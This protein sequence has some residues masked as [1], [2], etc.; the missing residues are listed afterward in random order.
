MSEKAGTDV[1]VRCGEY[2]ATVTEYSLFLTARRMLMQTLPPPL[3][4]SSTVHARSEDEGD[5][6][7]AATCMTSLL[8]PACL[9]QLW[10]QGQ[11]DNE[12]DGGVDERKATQSGRGCAAPTSS[13]LMFSTPPSGSAT[14]DRGWLRVQ[15]ALEYTSVTYGQLHAVTWAQ[16]EEIRALHYAEYTP[17]RAPHCPTPADITASCVLPVEVVL[18]WVHEG[19][20]HRV[21]PAELAVLVATAADH[22]DTTS[23]S[24]T[25][26][27][28]A[29]RVPGQHLT[30]TPPSI[31]SSSL[32]VSST[33]GKR[34]SSQ[35]PLPL[36]SASTSVSCPLLTCVMELEYPPGTL[37]ARRLPL[38]LAEPLLTRCELIELVRTTAGIRRHVP[39]RV[40]YRVWPRAPRVPGVVASSAKGVVINRSITISSGDSV[41]RGVGTYAPTAGA[42]PLRAIESDTAVAMLVRDVLAYGSAALRVVAVVS[43]RAGAAPPSTPDVDTATATTKVV[44]APTWASSCAGAEKQRQGQQQ[45]KDA[46]STAVKVDAPAWSTPPAPLSAAATAPLPTEKRN[47]DDNDAVEEEEEK[48]EP[49]AVMRDAPPSSSLPPQHQPRNDTATKTTAAFADAAAAF[50]C[51]SSTSNNNDIGDEVEVEAAA[52]S[53]LRNANNDDLLDRGNAGG[54]SGG[55]TV[56]DVD[57]APPFVRSSGAAR[58]LFTRT[59]S[60]T[61]H[62]Q[63]STTSVAATGTAA[64]PGTSRDPLTRDDTTTTA[65]TASLSTS[66]DCSHHSHTR[67]PPSEQLLSSEGSDAVGVVMRAMEAQ[68]LQR[69]VHA[70]SSSGGGCNADAP[71]T[72][73]ADPLLSDAVVVVLV[74]EEETDNNNVGRVDGEASEMGGNA[75]THDAPTQLRED[76]FGETWRSPEHYGRHARERAA[77]QQKQQQQQQQ[78]QQPFVERKLA[79]DA[80]PHGTALWDRGGALS[81]DGN[82]APAGMA[83][84]A[85]GALLRSPLSAT[86]N[87]SPRLHLH[88]AKDDDGDLKTNPKAALLISASRTNSSSPSHPLAAAVAA[89]AA[90]L[91]Q[92]TNPQLLPNGGSAV[93]DPRSLV[94]VRYEVDP[95]AVYVTGPVS[96]AVLQQLQDVIF[97]RCC[98]HLSVDDVD[99][100]RPRFHTR[101]DADVDAASHPKSVK[102]DTPS[103]P[104]GLPS[105]DND[106][107]PMKN[108]SPAAAAA[109]PHVEYVLPLHAYHFTRAEE[110]AL[111][112]CI[113]EVMAV[114]QGLEQLP[115]KEAEEWAV[116]THTVTTAPHR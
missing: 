59:T 49:D 91:S 82:D 58:M 110:S 88:I 98:A 116:A 35:P 107:A 74:D 36:P 56:N 94:F 76:N 25:S 20:V 10:L 21:I 112:C 92:P 111:E 55:A 4:S 53:H 40:A 33:A 15:P 84:H 113:A 79:A 50:L 96:P 19:R 61:I 106:A 7:V 78:Q 6:T 23:A 81:T 90:P 72:S 39:L 32:A 46:T 51:V 22:P 38:P 68:R 95:T 14:V 64:A 105:S 28:A 86:S 69:Q 45:Q 31:P 48:G 2:T 52:A 108:A 66:E 43:A 115:T 27:P 65:T 47:N 26:A 3:S 57:D 1:R 109:W 114:Y 93:L 44:V 42:P 24:A 104:M 97:R 101:N 62:H 13:S 77:V 71:T 85:H 73:S 63:P 103:S 5:E 70:S 8:L 12:E 87:T 89:P 54:G 102:A 11:E 9:L 99:A 29:I 67:V 60:S 17:P 83:D 16:W 41:I 30:P 37:L 80:A 34:R 18:F 75:A 100:P